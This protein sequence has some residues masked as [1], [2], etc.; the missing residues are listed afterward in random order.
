MCNFLDSVGLFSQL[1]CTCQNVCLGIYF[2]DNLKNGVNY[3]ACMKYSELRKKG[4]NFIFILNEEQP[5]F[6]NQ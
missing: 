6:A 4:Q 5:F 1:L 2:A 3:F